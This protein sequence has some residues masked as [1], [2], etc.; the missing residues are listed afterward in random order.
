MGKLVTVSAKIPEE[1]KQKMEE[2]SIRP[3]EIIRKAIE[4][5]VYLREVEK[6]KEML[7]EAEPILAKL[8]VERAVRSI[9]EDRGSR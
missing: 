9:R 6:I 5:E 3:S 8:S 7:E 4:E 1:L 2:L